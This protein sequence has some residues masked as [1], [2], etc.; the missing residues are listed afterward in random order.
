[1]P[2]FGGFASG[3]R[4]YDGAD[5]SEY[6]G[7]MC[8]S[9]AGAAELID[10]GAKRVQTVHWGVDPELYAPLDIPED[11][12]VFFYGLGA[13]FREQWIESMLIEPSRRMS[14]CTFALSGSGFAGDFG[15]VMKSDAIPFNT[16]RQACCRSR[17]NL[18]IARETHANAY[19]SSTLRPFELTAMARC[20][21]TSPYQGMETWFDEPDHFVT[22][23][24]ADEAI[25][26]YTRLLMD[27]STRRAM[28]QSARQRVLERHT[29]RH[30]AAEIVEF[31]QGV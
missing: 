16:V 6:D 11:R 29:H 14:E 30:R 12:D 18:N 26:T 8:N 7:F 25:E 23:R 10:M 22:V 27:P 19:A 31:V 5:L 17:I 24:N 20:M 3:F 9:E 1:L 4:I 13:E 15:N 21:V 28:G 2:R